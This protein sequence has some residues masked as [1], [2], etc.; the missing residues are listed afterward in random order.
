M[1][2][3]S[4]PFHLTGMMIRDRK[5]SRV[6]VTMI[7]SSNLSGKCAR[8]VPPLVA[9]R[10]III[11]VDLVNSA[12][13]Y[14]VLNKTLSPKKIPLQ[15]ED[16]P[17][18]GKRSYKPVMVD[19]GEARTRRLEEYISITDSLQSSAPLSFTRVGRERGGCHRWEDIPSS[20][21]GKFPLTENGTLRFAVEQ[22]TSVEAR[23]EALTTTGPASRSSAR[24]PQKY[25]KLFKRPRVEG[26]RWEDPVN[27][28]G[29]FPALK[30]GRVG[31]GNVAI[32]SRLFVLDE[33]QT[34]NE[35][36]ENRRTILGIGII[37]ASETMKRKRTR[38]RMRDGN[39]KR[40]GTQNR[41]E[42]VQDQK[43]AEK[44]LAKTAS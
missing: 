21:F 37:I 22:D 25:I 5:S 18:A 13:D 17:E 28:T 8:Q 2:R 11:A 43:T 10:I 7:R 29:P 33:M 26:H 4:P 44:E 30:S 3:A 42:D 15:I 27:T 19:F 40:T 1:R 31:T 24:M 32:E 36:V 35:L 6:T 9:R 34:L 12:H 14:D 23:L 20:K 16:D 39:K 38:V 41:W